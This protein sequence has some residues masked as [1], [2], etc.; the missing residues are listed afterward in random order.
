MGKSPENLFET[1]L[2]Y[3]AQTSG[4]VESIHMY[5][6]RAGA[7]LGRIS[8]ITR[9]TLSFHRDTHLPIAIDVGELPAGVVELFEKFAAARHT[10]SPQYD[11]GQKAGCGSV[12]PPEEPA[13]T[14]A[15]NREPWWGASRHAR[16]GRRARQ[17]RRRRQ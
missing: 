10:G 8:R 15:A 17:Y 13:G 9:Q 16:R 7:E 5:L 12:R 11:P 3:L 2:L 14:V 4:S 1:N 6:A